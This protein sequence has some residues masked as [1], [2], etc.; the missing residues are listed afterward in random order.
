MR[1]LGSTS[2]RASRRR[3]QRARLVVRKTELI[4]QYY[5]ALYAAAE[6]GAQARSA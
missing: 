3:S 2:R 6:G 5:D 4:A 1:G